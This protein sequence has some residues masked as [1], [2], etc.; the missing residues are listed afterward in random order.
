MKRRKYRALAGLTLIAVCVTCIATGCQ[1]MDDKL[2][3]IQLSDI[4]DK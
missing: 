3:D 4:Q 1:S 2:R